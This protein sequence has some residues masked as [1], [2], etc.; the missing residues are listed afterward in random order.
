MWKALPHVYVVL[1][2]LARCALAS[3][4]GT[5]LGIGVLKIYVTSPWFWL[6]LFL[7]IPETDEALGS[8]RRCESGKVNASKP[9][10]DMS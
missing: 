9:S 10:D 3:R 7:S 6:P 2:F 1:Y 5:A 4:Q 8:R